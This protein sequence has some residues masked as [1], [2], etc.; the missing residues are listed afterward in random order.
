MKI[1]RNWPK[2][3]RLLFLG[4]ALLILAAFVLALFHHHADGRDHQDCPVCQLIQH[5]SAL[6]LFSAVAFITALAALKDFPT[7]TF[8]F[9]P[10]LLPS[11]LQG[12]APPRLS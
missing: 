5:F 8:S 10:L 6:A 3:K 9:V 7:Q 11:N 2:D 12:R 1:S 4:V